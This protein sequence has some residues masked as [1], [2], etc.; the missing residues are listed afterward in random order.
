M[1]TI[2]VVT[3]AR[4]DYGY[5]LPILRR[6][7]KDRGLKLRLLVSGAHLSPEFGMTVNAI[8]KD[9][10]RV[11]ERIPAPL[12][13]DSPEGIA[14][15]EGQGVAGFGRA[16]ARKRPDI[17][18]VLGDRYEMQA[19]VVAA[20][21]FRIPVAHIHGGESTEGAIDEQIRHSIT[22]MSH[23][24]FASTRTYARRIIQMGEEPWRVTVSGAP[25]LD[26]L[27][28]LRLL[29]RPELEKTCRID[30][31]G[32]ALLVTYHPVTLEPQNTESRIRELLAALARSRSRIV[33]TYPGAD[34]SSRLIIRR[35]KKFVSGNPRK[36]ALAANL[37]TQTYF[38]LMRHAAA[39]VGNSSS[40]I[41]EAASFKLPV[42]N[43]G[44]RQQGRIRGRN[45][46]DVGENRREIIRGIEQAL[47]RP[48]RK[49]LGSLTNPYGN[50]H[51]SKKIVRALKT[52]KIDRRLI[53]KKFH[54]V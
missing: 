53:M 31:G 4:S 52:V 12:S 34:T 24:H 35:I 25:S 50:G 9:G 17:L 11:D 21:P 47:S 6:I 16:Y 5:Y 18:L 40:G 45:V 13:S 2:A 33:F 38:S 32:P 3:V 48:F 19:A 49:S 51:A 26:N 29:S 8:R 20:L 15:S 10:F 41:V 54:E 27:K 14:R 46:I 37:G 22:K 44:I 7:Q 23:L 42:V 43:I 28:S 39:M 1:R 36:R 30:L